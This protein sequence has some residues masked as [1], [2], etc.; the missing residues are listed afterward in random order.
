MV[1]LQVLDYLGTMV[2]AAS[3]ALK[4]VRKGMDVFGV[5]VLAC[6]TAIGGGTLRDA[7][8][9]RRVFWL[10]DRTYILLSVVVALGVFWLYRIAVK[11]ERLLL[12]LDAIGLGVFTA[13]GATK[14]YDAQTGTVGV[15]TLACLTGVG[16]GLIRDVLSGDVPIVLREEIYASASIAGA[17][18]FGGLMAIGAPPAVTLCVSAGLT[19]LIRILSI[20]L[21][22]HMPRR[23]DEVQDQ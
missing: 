12:I 22:W 8:L 4:G 9:D 11:T 14:A 16:G 5:A 19:V 23:P 3:G 13:I 21:H 1:L 17:L 18:V 7:L 6:V 20:I 2:F 10:E 15:V